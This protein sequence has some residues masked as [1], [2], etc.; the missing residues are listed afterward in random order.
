MDRWNETDYSM[1]VQIFSF[2]GFFVV[3]MNA[4]IRESTAGLVDHTSA[5]TRGRL[6]G[7]RVMALNPACPFPWLESLPGET[8][9]LRFEVVTLGFTSFGGCSPLVLIGAT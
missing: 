3:L 9:K 5:I 7:S 8:F 1:L 2:C 4:M 6:S